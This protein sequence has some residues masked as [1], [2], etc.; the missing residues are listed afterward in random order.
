MK[1]GP[2]SR[3]DKKKKTL[4]KHFTMTPCQRIMTS[5]SFFKIM[6][7]LEQSGSRNEDALP[8]KLKFS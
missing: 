1:L 5:L 2:V 7:N 3:L 8:I 6:D 4:Q